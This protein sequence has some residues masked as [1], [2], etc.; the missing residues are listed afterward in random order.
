MAE[1][2]CVALIDGSWHYVPTLYFLLQE[3]GNF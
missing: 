2:V 3:K 1:K